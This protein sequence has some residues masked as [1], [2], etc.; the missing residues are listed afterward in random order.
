VSSSSLYKFLVPNPPLHRRTERDPEDLR[1]PPPRRE[2]GRLLE[3]RRIVPGL[4]RPSLVSSFDGTIEQILFCFPAWGV[5]DP[6]VSAGYRSVIGALRRGTRFVVVHAES[7]RDEVAGW[8]TDAG[9]DRSDVDLVGLPDYVSFTDW[10]EDGYVA[11]TDLEDGTTYLVEPWTFPRA[12]DALIADAVSDALPIRSQQAP[13]V[14]QGGNCLVGEGFWLL[15]RDYFADTLSL[16]GEPRPPAQPPGSVSLPDF[17][18]QLFSDYVDRD[19]RLVLVGTTREIPLSTFRGLRSGD[20]FFLDLPTDG[21]GT[22]QPVF[23]IDM[24]LTLVGPGEDDRFEVLVGDP[25]LADDL[26]GTQ[27][28]WA[29][30][31]VYDTIA[32]DLAREGFAVQRNPLVHW[33]TTTRALTFAEISALA[34]QPDNEALATAVADLRE[35]GAGRDTPVT[36]RRWHHVT[37]NNCLVENSTEQGKHVYLPTF[38]Y[39]DKASLAVVDDH[40]EQLWRD[41]DFEVHRLGDFNPFAERQGVV[42]CIKKY[43]ARS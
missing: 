18:R 22:Y 36:V 33:P 10:A 1:T 41:R 3:A 12:G 2:A 11:L 35:Q 30:P 24:F 25:S 6:A 34:D 15:G 23:H 5:A 14:F 31:G 40:M 16:L 17:A 42:H 37:W 4:Q 38:G 13:L 27:S 19:R 26:L 28:P 43:L 32:A 8:F 29:L 21:T 7:T 39:A 9:H 20:E